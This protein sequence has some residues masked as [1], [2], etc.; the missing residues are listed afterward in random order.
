[1]EFG[2]EALRDSSAEAGQEAPAPAR[3]T[4]PAEIEIDDALVRGLLRAQH[5]DMADLPLVLTATGWDNCTYRLGTELA[6]RVPRRKLAGELLARE[7]ELLPLLA[8]RVTVRVPVPVRLGRP[9]GDYPWPW[10]IVPWIPGRSTEHEALSG[11]QAGALGSFLSALHRP[12]PPQIPRSTYRGMPLD[13]CVR[14]EDRIAHLST[15]LPQEA[16]EGPPAATDPPVRRAAHP[17]GVDWAALLDLW[18][19]AVEAPR[20]VPDTWI[21]AD[22]HPKNVLGDAGRLAAVIDWGDTCLGDPATDLAAAWMHFPVEDHA[23]F[24]QAYGGV[25][26]ATLLRA[27]GWAVFFGTMLLEHGSVDDRH[28]ARIGRLTLRRLAPAPR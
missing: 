20:D 13:R 7:Q 14:V 16:P 9:G 21:H 11:D 15:G 6:V 23:R 22:L 2:Q 1:M 25:S 5:P 18:R 8:P 19:A 10:S 27:R 17:H 4:P 3:G 24:R 26:P 12:E 28:F